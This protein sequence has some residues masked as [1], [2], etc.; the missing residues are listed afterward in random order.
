MNERKNGEEFK[1][2]DTIARLPIVQQENMTFETF[3]T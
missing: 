3:Q 2:Y 1:N